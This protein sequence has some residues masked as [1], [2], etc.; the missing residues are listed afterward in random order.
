MSSIQAVRELLSQGQALSLEDFASLGM[1]RASVYRSLQALVAEGVVARV[2]RG[3]YQLTTLSDMAD[4]W[5]MA[6]RAVPEGV[7]CLLSALAFHQLGTQLPADVWLA[8]PKSAYRAKVDYPPIQYVHFSGAAFT[9]GVEEHAMQGG[10]VRV[11]SVAKTIA[12][13]FKFRNRI[14][15][16]VALEALKEALEQRRVTVNELLHM[17]QVCRVQAVMTPYIDTLVCG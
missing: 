11:F 13:G 10:K 2:R 4:T 8:I 17:A 6:T 5:V 7:L 1:S 14:G 12:D 3:H 15:L 9:V 16:D